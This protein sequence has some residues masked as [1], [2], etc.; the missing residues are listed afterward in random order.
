MIALNYSTYDVLTI[1]RQNGGPVNPTE[2]Q[3]VQ[4]DADLFTANDTILVDIMTQEGIET[5]KDNKSTVLL[6][7]RFGAGTVPQRIRNACRYFNNT[8]NL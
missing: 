1:F 5:R 4:F 3:I 8:Q 7:S 2:D 6:F